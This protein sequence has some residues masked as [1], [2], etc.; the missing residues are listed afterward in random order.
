MGGAHLRLGLRRLLGTRPRGDQLLHDPPRPGLPALRRGDLR[1]APGIAVLGVRFLAGLDAPRFA[2]VLASEP[3]RP[4]VRFGNA[5]SL[6]PLRD[7]LARD[8]HQWQIANADSRRTA[9]ARPPNTT[10]ERARPPFGMPIGHGIRASVKPR[11]TTPQ[12]RHSSSTTAPRGAC[13]AA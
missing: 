11:T 6:P 1:P 13:G 12:S 9:S 4:F 10:S 5:E 3:V 8:A 2:G 7:R